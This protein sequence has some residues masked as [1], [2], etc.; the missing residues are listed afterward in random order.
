MPYTVFLN[1][2][3]T[4]YYKY[5]G[6]LYGDAFLDVIREVAAEAGEGK[7]ALGMESSRIEY[8]PPARL[9]NQML[10]ELPDYFH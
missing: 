4:L 1:P 5:T 8:Q 10:A 2:D 6:T 7:Y 9:D 3:G